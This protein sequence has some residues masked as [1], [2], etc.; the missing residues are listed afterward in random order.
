MVIAF[1]EIASAM[2]RFEKKDPNISLF[3]VVKR[4]IDSTMKCYREICEENKNVI[5]QSFL[6]KFVRK[7]EKPSHLSHIRRHPPPLVPMYPCKPTT[8]IMMSIPSPVSSPSLSPIKNPVV[9][10]QNFSFSEPE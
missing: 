3:L 5:F 8:N 4:W 2:A 1:H 7:F 9:H 6:N 10:H